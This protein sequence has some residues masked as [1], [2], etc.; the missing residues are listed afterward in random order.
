MAPEIRV[1]AD[2]GV[3]VLQFHRIAGEPDEV[4]TDADSLD[5][6][7]GTEVLTVEK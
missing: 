5:L 2:D 3:A 6:V 7:Q 4:K 1:G